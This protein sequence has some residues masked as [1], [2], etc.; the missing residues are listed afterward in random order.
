LPIYAKAKELQQQNDSVIWYA[1]Y[2]NKNY[3]YVVTGQWE[4][5]FMSYEGVNNNL[6]YSMGLVDETGAT[7]IP[8]EY[9]LI[10]T[11]G[12][13]Q[14][15]IVEVK[16]EGKAG[17][18]NIETKELLIPAAY[19]LVIPYKHQQNIRAIVK[20]D[21]VYGW[22]DNNMQYQAGLPSEEV[23]KW[24]DSFEFI[25]KD[26]QLKSDK[27]SF[28]E[29]PVFEQAGFGIVMPPSYLVKTGL[30]NEI[31]GGISTTSFPLNGWTDYLETKGTFIQQVTEKINAVVT[32]ITERYLDGRE[33]FY[34]HNRLVFVNAK[35]DTLAVSNIPANGTADLK[36]IDGGIL[37]IK[38]PAP[39]SWIEGELSEDYNLP[40]Y[41]YFLIGDAAT[42]KKLE[43]NRVFPSTAFVKIDSSYLTG[44]FAHWSAELKAEEA[45]TFLSLSSLD[46][47][48][49]EILA[50][51]GYKFTND[52]TRSQFANHNWYK[53]TYD[54]VDEFKDQLTEI[55][56]YN[57]AFIERVINAMKNNP[58]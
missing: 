19:D 55:D 15:F 47:M 20:T 22:I 34:T 43:S 33:E 25:P 58:T 57:L 38:S 46:Y 52:E 28:C 7:I 26:L 10:G 14:P 32:T 24:I 41:N 45:T 2:Q 48:Y 6:E 53:P 21:S 27:Q 37:E 30:F 4:N 29:I 51:Y 50:S 9:D 23:R 31:I 3:F 54:T 42:I 44:N 56:R 1:T 11:I 13:E 16:K 40:V 8:T 5:K 35:N 36:R 12:F 39:D 18:F 17:W 49:N